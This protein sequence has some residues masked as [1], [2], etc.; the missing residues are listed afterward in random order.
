MSREEAL[1]Q[2]PED[3]A[4][5]TSR[6]AVIPSPGGKEKLCHEFVCQNDARQRFIV[7]VNAVS[8]EQEKI[9]LLLEDE[10]GSLTL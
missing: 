9:L 5:E 10:N 4:V 7:Y 1:K 6:L 2:L 3:L 8:G